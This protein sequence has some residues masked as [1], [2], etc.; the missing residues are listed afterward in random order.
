MIRH[1]AEIRALV[2]SRAMELCKK[3]QIDISWRHGDESDLL[4]VL[5]LRDDQDLALEVA[6]VIMSR[7]GAPP[8]SVKDPRFDKTRR[9]IASQRPKLRGETRQERELREAQGLELQARKAGLT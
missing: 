5:A 8:P 6:T 9:A 3:L 2:T 7:F 4:V 1:P